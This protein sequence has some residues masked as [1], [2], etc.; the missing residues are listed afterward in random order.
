VQGGDTV[1]VL[2]HLIA[3]YGHGDLAFAEVVQRLASL[4]PDA[5][6]LPTPVPPFDTVSAGFCAAQ[7]A[8]ADDPGPRLVYTNVAPRTDHPDPRPGNQGERLVAARCPSGVI[9]VGVN[10]RHCFS[11]LRGLAE[12]RAV[13]VPDAGSQFRSRDLFP[14]SVA[15][16]ARGD[17][18]CLGEVVDDALLPPAPEHAVA[19]VDG[20]GNLKTTWHDSPASLGEQVQ[21]TVGGATALA[22]V[23]DGT[24]AV[25]Q[26]DMTFAPGSRGWAPAEGR[27]TFNEVL[28]PGGCAAE[29]LGRPR[30]GAPVDV[31]PA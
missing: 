25:R 14:A 11:F 16:L 8:L 2:V 18:S 9:V 12:V 26:G 13:D 15:A 3:D 6:V 27:N 5:V 30:A 28:L 23:T 4:L 17:T 24:F 21:V 1:V 20:Y 29:R 31:Q 22:T 10:S 19:Y 7:L